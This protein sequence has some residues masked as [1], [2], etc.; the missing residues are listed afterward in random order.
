MRVRAQR[1]GTSVDAIAQ[2]S[3]AAIYLTSIQVIRWSILKQSLAEARHVCF[4]MTCAICCLSLL[5]LPMHLALSRL[6]V[7]VLRHAWQDAHCLQGR[8][9]GDPGNCQFSFGDGRLLRYRPDIR[10][11]AAG[12]TIALTTST[13]RHEKTHKGNAGCCYEIVSSTNSWPLNVCSRSC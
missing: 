2:G 4:G 8:I 13:R 10:I 11:G 7:Y 12:R 6:R 3:A 1:A 9:W 5:A